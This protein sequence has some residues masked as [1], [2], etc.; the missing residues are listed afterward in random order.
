MALVPDRP[1][2]ILSHYNRHQKSFDE[3]SHDVQVD[4]VPTDD[5]LCSRSRSTRLKTTI[6]DFLRKLGGAD[7][8]DQLPNDDYGESLEGEQMQPR[9]V[10][11]QHHYLTLDP[12]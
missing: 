6:S 7:F 8:Y 12:F 5:K 2:D 9:M 11:P 1:R 4:G 10:L 3:Y